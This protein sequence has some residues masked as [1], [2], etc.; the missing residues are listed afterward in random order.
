MPDHEISLQKVFLLMLLR[1]IKPSAGH[2]NGTRYV[3]VRMTANLP[4]LTSVSISKTESRLMLPRMNCTVSKDDFPIL[5]FRRCQFPIRVCFAMTINKAQGQ[6]I[7]GALGIDLHGQCFSHGKLYVALSRT[8]S[9]RN[10]FICTAN[11]TKKKKVSCSLKFLIRLT[12][13]PEK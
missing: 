7:P 12:I 9:P 4:F 6:S 5:D 10:V 8:T 13:F 11:G 1:N 2:V 3:V